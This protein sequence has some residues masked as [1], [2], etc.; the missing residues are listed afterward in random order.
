MRSPSQTRSSKVPSEYTYPLL[1]QKTSFPSYFPKPITWKRKNWIKV[2]RGK[3]FNMCFY[4]KNVLGGT[5]WLFSQLAG[6][7]PSCWQRWDRPNLCMCSS[8]AWVPPSSVLLQP[9]AWANVFWLHQCCSSPV[10]LP[11]AKSPLPASKQVYIQLSSPMKRCTCSSIHL[12]IHI[13]MLGL[14]QNIPVMAS[15]EK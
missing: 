8:T 5:L 2:R 13:T 1:W 15:C 4:M 14:E 6:P 11:S 9:G 12:D 3:C 7:L 10:Q